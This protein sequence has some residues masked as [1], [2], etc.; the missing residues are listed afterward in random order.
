MG[1]HGPSRALLVPEVLQA[2]ALDCGPAAL[3][4]LLEGFGLGLPFD[5]LRDACRTGRDGT[6]IDALEAVAVERG[7]DAEQVLV[8]IDH[9]PMPEAGCLPCI[10]VGMQ[11]GGAAHFVAL[12]RIHGGRAQ[13]MDPAA[14]RRWPTLAALERE[15]YRHGA[16]VGAAAWH[17]WALSEAGL[18]PLA[19]R[20]AALGLAA[21][22]RE[23]LLRG[24]IAGRGWRPV[25]AL[26]AATRFVRELVTAGGIR[27]GRDASWLLA[28]LFERAAAP[29]G[30]GEAG[31]ATRAVSYGCRTST[32]CAVVPAG[33]WTVRP[34]APDAGDP[35]GGE[36]LLC[37]GAVLVRIR[38]LLP[39]AARRGTWRSASSQLP[40]SFRG[41]RAGQRDAGGAE[42]RE[43]ARRHLGG[44]ASREDDID[45][46]AGDRGR[47]ER[48]RGRGALSPLPEGA[49]DRAVLVLATAG[50]AVGRCAE[51]LLLVAALELLPAVP[52][53]RFRVGVLAALVTVGTALLFFDLT[54]AGSAQALGRRRE[55]GLRLRLAAKLPRLPDR[56]LRT[57]LLADLAERAHLL[58]H[59]RRGP[60]LAAAG[61]R[62]GLEGLLAASG[63]AWLDP[64][65]GAA[66]LGAGVAAML[67]PWLLLRR[68]EERS[69]RMR[70]HAGALG[71]LYLDVLRGLAAIRAHG[72]GTAFRRRH[73][74][75]L[76]GWLRARR[77]ADAAGA[78]LETG[79]Q[80]LLSLAL[81]GLVLVHVRRE[82][83]DAR[84]LVLVL[85]AF[86]LLG[87]GQR[88]ALLAGRDLPLHRSLLRRIE[89]PL[90][91]A[92]EGDATGAVD[93]S[94]ARDAR[95]AGRANGARGVT[96]AAAE[97]RVAGGTGPS[98]TGDAAAAAESTPGE[99]AVRGD[100]PGRSAVPGA[101]ARPAPAA[102]VGGGA[103]QARARRART[104]VALAW[105]G[106]T[107]EVDGQRLLRDL[108]LAIPGGQHVAVVGRSGCGKSTLFGTLLGWHRP[109]AGRLLVD[110]RLLDAAVLAELRRGTAWA[111]PEVALWRRSL[112]GNLCDDM[113]AG[114]PAGRS[115]NAGM[116][117]AEALRSSLLLELVSQLP[118]GLQTALGEGGGRLSGGEA[119]RLRF[120][121]ALLHS[122]ARLALLDEPFRGL[123]ADQRRRL[124]GVARARWRDA[125][126]LCITHSPAEAAGFDRVLVLEDG[127]LVEDGRPA[128]LAARR[129]SRYRALLDAEER[130]AGALQA[131][132]WRRL[133]LADG[134][135]REVPSGA[136]VPPGA[137]PAASRM[138][139]AGLRA[140]GRAPSRAGG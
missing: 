115:V 64:A 109:A 10:L 39:P 22:E 29:A 114:G 68:C 131:P 132:G 41:R 36:R 56:Y 106:L 100:Q 52:S 45:S 87:A 136:A 24:A 27:R 126:L 38:G 7:L 35:A 14:G 13:L 72:A 18:R 28:T 101:A 113:G 92:E 78:G 104:G 81:A 3:A 17:A 58:T 65:L 122:A 138:A 37:T 25:A 117:P 54:A 79:T 74:E 108:D 57:R 6:S 26:D 21:A 99:A 59:L 34:V 121:R 98:C 80:A 67:V 31:T 9:L 128:A 62:A 134:R 95:G 55:M 60:D 1:G 94:G 40:R 71:G 85:W 107:V 33:C 97:A 112:L 19:A 53:H 49:G 4:S 20:L 50:G 46:P 8:P 11:P 86:Q 73:D 123:G 30:G 105:V 116:A 42:N 93:D 96:G 2:S 91:A 139:S 135:L 111:A 120:A 61:L 83:L 137:A 84:T 133:L 63:I 51:T 77:G 48:R 127:S 5:R 47:A 118:Q 15:T 130:A 16:I 75:M 103:A 66:A 43:R 124:L 12:W 125:T 69:R 88:L 89:E 32:T 70:A 76:A 90:A 129:G 119:Q 82:G 44:R 23:A 102:A 110:G 140:S